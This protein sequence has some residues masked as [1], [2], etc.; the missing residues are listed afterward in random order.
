MS[1]EDSCAGGLQ[2]RKQAALILGYRSTISIKR[3]EQAGRLKPIWINSRVVRYRLEDIEN[4]IT[5][6][7]G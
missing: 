1:A 4:L 5:N 7:G 2:D 3:L 6:G